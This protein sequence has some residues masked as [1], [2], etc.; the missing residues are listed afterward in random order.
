[1]NYIEGII[2]RYM[3]IANITNIK[4]KYI[5]KILKNH[6]IRYNIYNGGGEVINEIEIFLLFKEIL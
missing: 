2:L 3:K 6:I 4:L 1:M 5:D